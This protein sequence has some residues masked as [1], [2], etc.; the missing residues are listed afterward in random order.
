MIFG[1]YTGGK[2]KGSFTKGMIYHTHNGRDDAVDLDRIK[3]VDNDGSE[4]FVDNNNFRFPDFVYGYFMNKHENPGQIVKIIDGDDSG[5]EIDDSV[6]QTWYSKNYVN[7]LHP[8][9]IIPGM[10]LYRRMKKKWFVVGGVGF[11]SNGGITV[12]RS[13]ECGNCGWKKLINFSL[14]LNEEGEVLMDP[15]LR[16]LDDT[17][18]S[19]T[20]GNVYM[21]IK[22]E[23]DGLVVVE[24]D[25]EEQESFDIKRFE[26][27]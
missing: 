24:N 11:D 9:M 19:L 5:Y 8:N 7:L 1:I 25:D 18:A 4:V 13:K 2:T 21:G 14:I 27:V 6:E 20:K 10:S 22:M 17:G 16:C 12:T 26:F 15:L 3:M 23:N